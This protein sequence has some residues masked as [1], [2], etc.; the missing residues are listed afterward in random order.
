MQEPVMVG[1]FIGYI[2]GVQGEWHLNIHSDGRMTWVVD[3]IPIHQSSDPVRIAEATTVLDK[4]IPR[5]VQKHAQ[6]PF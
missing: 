5:R 4:I 1:W 3:G 2:N 6:H